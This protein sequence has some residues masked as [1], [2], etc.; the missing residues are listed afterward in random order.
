MKNKNKVLVASALVVALATIASAQTGLFKGSF[1][2]LRKYQISS[3]ECSKEVNKLGIFA[4]S[5]GKFVTSLASEV[6]SLVGSQ[7]G[8]LVYSDV[9]TEHTTGVPSIVVSEGG[10][11]IVFSDVTTTYS[12]DVP[13][14]VSSWLASNN[15]SSV[16]SDV[17]L[18]K[19]YVEKCLTLNEK[20]AIV[21]KSRSKAIKEARE[22]INKAKQELRMYNSFTK[23][24]NAETSVKS[25][26]INRKIETKS[27]T[28]NTKAVNLKK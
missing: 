6:Y 17:E 27:N 13:S 12:S 18:D 22:S 28:L 25:N 24:L 15:S 3:S 26:T 8:S 14:S 5:N 20:K 2:D 11:S 16:S 23:E 1:N 10:P 9:P 21:K 7:V 4:S 19:S